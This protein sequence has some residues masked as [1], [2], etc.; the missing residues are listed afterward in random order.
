V[1]VRR[2]A[3]ALGVLVALAACGGGL[4]DGAVTIETSRGPVEVEVEIAD[5]R[6]ER[7]RGLMGRES[8]PERA[9]MLFLIGE[10]RR[11]GFWM[12][13]TLV[14]LSIAFMDGGGRILAILDMEPCERDPCPRYDPGVAYRSALEVNRG[15]FRRWGVEPGDVVTGP[16]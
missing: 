8:L 14:P 10:E 1:G 2:T 11:G 13:D 3:A 7:R 4:E 9:G 15:A 5:E 16:G 12:K 6:D